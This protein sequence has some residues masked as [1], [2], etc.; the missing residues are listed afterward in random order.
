[1]SALA[2]TWL[3]PPADCGSARLGS[4]IGGCTQIA[5]DLDAAEALMNAGQVPEAVTIL[6]KFV[7]RKPGATSLNGWRMN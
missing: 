5:A 3:R 6:A 7:A 1:M 4:S 2:A